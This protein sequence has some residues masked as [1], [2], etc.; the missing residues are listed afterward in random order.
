VTRI[1]HH[2]VLGVSVS[3]SA[4]SGLAFAAA[5]TL[6][7]A[8]PAVSFAEGHGKPSAAEHNQHHGKK[9]VKHFT[10][11]GVFVSAGSDGSTFT[12]DVKGGSHDQHGKK[13]VVITV[14]SKT[15]FSRHDSPTTLSK[16]TAGDRVAVNGVRG[17][18]GEF[19]ALHVNVHSK[20]E[21]KPSSSESPEPQ[22]SPSAS[23]SPDASDSPDTTN[24][25]TPEPTDS[26]SS[27]PTP[28]PTA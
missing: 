4:H 24:T 5:A 28:T 7:L 11:T 20:P 2:P 9:E 16:L 18:N 13:A 12:M 8:A 19:D 15:K 1:D 14:T 25:P 23:G 6:V 26:S 22:A 10:A 21:P 27:E 17:A 3:L